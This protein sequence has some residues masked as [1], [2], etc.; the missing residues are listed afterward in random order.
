[1]AMCTSLDQVADIIGNGGPHN[2]DTTFDTVEA[3][4]DAVVRLGNQPDVFA[5][6][7]DHLGL[8][9]GLSKD[10][11]QTPLDEVDEDLFG[12]EIEAVLEQANTIIPLAERELTEDD[13]D[14]IEEDVRSRGDSAYD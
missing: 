6:H 9:E 10:F 12:A 1:M 14:D 13:E 7:D 3:L 11:L 2:P 5:F 4:V 8:K